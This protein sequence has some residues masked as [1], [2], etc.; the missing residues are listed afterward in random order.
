MLFA[1]R[2]E[3]SRRPV[4][5]DAGFDERFVTIHPFQDRLAPRRR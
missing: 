4:V 3:Q 5:I 1:D 2:P